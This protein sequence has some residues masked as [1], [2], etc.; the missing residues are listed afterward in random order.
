[1]IDQHQNLAEPLSSSKEDIEASNQ[2]KR[3]HSPLPVHESGKLSIPMNPDDDRKKHSIQFDLTEEPEVE[4]RHRTMADY[5]KIGFIALGVGLVIFVLY[6]TFGKEAFSFMIGYLSDIATTDSIGNYLILMFSH[7]I[8][9]W[10]LFVPG[11]STF[12]IL[13]AFLM[14]SF[15]KPF[16]ISFLG[17]YMASFS[18]VF[19]I[20]KYFRERIVEKF[21]RQILFQIVYLEV[22][23]RPYQM[24]VLFNLLF[25]PTNLKNYLMALT[26]ITL[27][28]YAIVILPVHLAYCAMFSAVG[29]SMKD[30]NSMFHDKPFSEKSTAE[31]T[32]TLVSYGMLLLTGGLM[33][34]FFLVAK[35]KYQEM[36]EIHRKRV[37]EEKNRKIEMNNIVTPV[38]ERIG[39]QSEQM[40]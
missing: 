18:I 10:I 37:E 19:I 26:S 32:Q 22:K 33:I 2:K 12:T 28:Q 31:K 21:K 16:I 40:T 5:V 11:H 14:Q 13:Q 35:S 4:E 30:I 34:A 9:G 29:Y 38:K 8:F 1:M 6:K 36:E 15:W 17:S 20:K 25:I 24:G 7:F 27:T 23:K 3:M 39:A